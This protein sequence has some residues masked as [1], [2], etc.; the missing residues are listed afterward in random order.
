MA[1]EMIA[2]PSVPLFNSPLETGV[3][4][5]VLLDATYPE[6]CNLTRLT[7]LDHLVV[8]THDIGGPASLHP[9]VPQRTGELLVRRRV[10]EEGLQLMRRLHMI[11]TVVDDEGI[12]YRAREEAS[13]MIDCMRTDYARALRERATWLAE[14][15][16]EMSEDEVNQLIAEKIGRWAVEFQGEAG[17]GSSQPL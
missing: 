3:R 6:A 16:S 2:H 5:I 14:K 9:D 4:S 15:L 17:Q 8:H 13:A 7:W 11:D 12:R 1:E 10:V